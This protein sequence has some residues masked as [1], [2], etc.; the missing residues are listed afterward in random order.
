M[1][2]RFVLCLLLLVA[3]SLFASSPAA[4]PSSSAAAVT[5][6]VAD[7]SGA[8]VPGAQ[9]DLLDAS[10]AVTG[11]SHSGDDGSFQVIPP[12]A[13]NFT[14]VVSESQQLV[15]C[16][17]FKY[18]QTQE[19]AYIIL[20]TLSQLNILPEEIKVLCHGEITSA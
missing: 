12:H 8:I 10:G 18:V 2:R 13:G 9:I 19:L 20:F 16:N 15:L 5:G 3:S 6:V 4:A 1:I 17:R 7:Q 14:L 11:T